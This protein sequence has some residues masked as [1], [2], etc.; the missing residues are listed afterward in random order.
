MKKVVLAS[1]FGLLI[2]YTCDLFAEEHKDSLVS[3]IYSEFNIPKIVFDLNLDKSDVLAKQS[4]RLSILSDTFPRRSLKNM[5]VHAALLNSEKS[6]VELHT[7]S[8][9]TLFNSMN[10]VLVE[11]DELL[12]TR[13][14][15]STQAAIN[16]YQINMAA[17]EQFFDILLAALLGEVPYDSSLKNQ[18]IKSAGQSRTTTLQIEA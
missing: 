12:I 8:F 4:I 11:G 7:E 13:T 5:W 6:M 15:S 3:G 10:E 16:G 14:E 2:S 18:L 1:M 17:S 9:I